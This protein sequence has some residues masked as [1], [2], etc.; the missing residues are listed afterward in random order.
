MD[1]A[2]KPE[3]GP[4]LIEQ[5]TDN[6]RRQRAGDVALVVK[7]RWRAEP[8]NPHRGA[9][10]LGHRFRDKRRIDPDF[11]GDL[12]D[13]AHRTLS[14]AAVGTFLQLRRA[15]ENERHLLLGVALTGTRQ[16]VV[17]RRRRGGWR[18]GHDAEYARPLPWRAASTALD[19]R[20]AP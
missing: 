17:R 4:R 15:L 14:A 12:L 11:R 13:L 3:L 16:V 2:V 8:S 19:S 18:V 5:L 1:F 6:A 9:P 10:Q 20:Q 7:A